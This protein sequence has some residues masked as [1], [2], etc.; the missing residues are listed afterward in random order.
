MVARV[1]AVQWGWRRP[2]NCAKLCS[3]SA[4]TRNSP[5]PTRRPFGEFGPGNG[6]YYLATSFDQIYLQPSGDIGLTGLMLESPFVKGT[7]EKLG[8]RFHGDHRYEYK[9]AHEHLHGNQVHRPPQGSAREGAELVV[10]AVEGWHLHN[11]RH[12][13]RINFRRWSTKVPTSARKRLDA[14]LVDGL[15]YRDE[16]YDQVKKKAAGDAEFL[17]LK[18]YL[19]RAGRPHDTA[20]RSH[21]C[22]G[23]VACRAAR[24]TTA[25]SAARRPWD[26]IRSRVRFVPLSRT[27]M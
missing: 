14:K 24:A 1:G 3:A 5:S 8:M 9:N 6:A 22:M 4:L 7:L 19:D 18:K 23:R 27:K 12:L 20:E 16:V 15:A 10:R 13:A 2:R 21:W 25:P 17:Y 11:P 26:R